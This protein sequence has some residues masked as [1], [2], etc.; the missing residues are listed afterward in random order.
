[1][2]AMHKFVK[3]SPSELRLYLD[4]VDCV[5]FADLYLEFFNCKVSLMVGN[6]RYFDLIKFSFVVSDAWLD[7]YYGDDE[8]DDVDNGL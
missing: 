3:V 2:D 4:V 8:F 1:V 6:Y 5:L 7:M